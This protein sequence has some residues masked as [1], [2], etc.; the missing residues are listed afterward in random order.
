MVGRLSKAQIGLFTSG[1]RKKVRSG[2]DVPKE[3]WA[4][5]WKRRPEVWYDFLVRNDDGGDGPTRSKYWLEI[6][7]IVFWF[8]VESLLFGVGVV[9]QGLVVSGGWTTISDNVGNIPGVAACWALLALFGVAERMFYWSVF[10][11]RIQHGADDDP[12]TPPSDR[13]RAQ[14]MCKAHHLLWGARMISNVVVA[15]F[16]ILLAFVT[17]SDNRPAHDWLTGVALG[18]FIFG[19][20][21]ATIQRI[22][23]T[24]RYHSGKWKEKTKAKAKSVEKQ[25]DVESVGS[26]SS[27]SVK[28]GGA[29]D[30]ADSTGSTSKEKKPA[31]TAI[32][33]ESYGVRVAWHFAECANLSLVWIFGVLFKWGITAPELYD[34][35]P[36]HYWMEYCVVFSAIS[37]GLY[38]RLD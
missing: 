36:G 25:E 21:C 4:S 24:E 26:A 7:Y 22:L 31:S 17:P 9:W 29:G 34:R 11:P 5:W 2:K 10:P 20:L 28:S 1:V 32:K 13:I 19:E 23:D 12:R 3:S 16:M 38:R 18:F 35:G 27:A 14:C 30:D 33:R 8:V 6:A 37:C 15:I